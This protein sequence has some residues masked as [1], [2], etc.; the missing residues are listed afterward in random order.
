MFCHTFG[1]N[2][3]KKNKEGRSHKNKF[4]TKWVLLA[5]LVLMVVFV[6]CEDVTVDVPEGAIRLIV[7]NFDSEE[8][9]D[10][11]HYYLYVYDEDETQVHHEVITP[12]HVEDTESSPY[13]LQDH[14]IVGYTD[15]F[16]SGMLFEAGTY[17]VKLEIWELPGTIEEGASSTL[18][19]TVIRKNV[20]V[21][22]GQTTDVAIDFAEAIAE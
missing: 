18:I 15:G 4:R 8:Q 19:E 11:H 2:I 21:L 7:Y 16:F 22:D 17:D 3:R 20:S 5:L 13:S 10:G 1:R 6:G 12:A 9:F 14:P